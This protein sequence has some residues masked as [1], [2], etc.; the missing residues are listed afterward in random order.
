MAVNSDVSNRGKG[1]LVGLGHRLECDLPNKKSLAPPSRQ[2]AHQPPTEA[3]P[4]LSFTEKLNAD[5]IFL[6]KIISKGTLIRRLY[7]TTSTR[8]NSYRDKWGEFD[9]IRTRRHSDKSWR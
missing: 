7:K 5:H 1:C 4:H 3:Q 8:N 9:V 6:S 2:P